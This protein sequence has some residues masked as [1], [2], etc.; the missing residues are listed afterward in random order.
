[1]Y[2]RRVDLVK[3]PAI[4]DIL[5]VWTFVPINDSSASILVLSPKM[6]GPD[7]VIWCVYNKGERSEIRLVMLE[8]L[9]EV[10][11]KGGDVSLGR[12]LQ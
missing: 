12:A 6:F 10:I 8:D 1:M 11:A 2:T 5:A 7:N 9:P 3:T 4:V